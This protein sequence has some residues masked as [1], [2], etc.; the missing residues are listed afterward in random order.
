MRIPAIYAPEKK[1]RWECP[2]END[3]RILGGPNLPKP[4]HGCAPRVYMGAQTWDR[5]R[6]RTY[7]MA[8][9]KCQICG[10]DCS[11]PGSMDAHELYTIDY[12]KGTS[13]FIKTVGIC[14][15]CHNFYH[16]GRLITL[17]KR[18]V[19]FY[20]ADVVL[21]IVEHGFKQIHEWNLNHPDEQ[22]LRAYGTFLEYLRQDSLGPKITELIDKYQIKFWLE[23]KKKMADWGDWK[24]L[25][26]KKE[27]ATPYKTYQDWEDAMEQA[28]KN[29]VMRQTKNPFQGEVFDE[30][31][32][33][34]ENAD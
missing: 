12:E 23:D 8:K 25:Y 22:P 15:A 27:Y 19:P 14:K 34:I 16:S 32:G 6:K 21:S 3:A 5:L 17:F 13:T 31:Q 28:S 30:I 18:G 10:A 4:L 20:S 11:D 24:L 7:Y 1:T 33:L 2:E 9:Y 26:G 29:D